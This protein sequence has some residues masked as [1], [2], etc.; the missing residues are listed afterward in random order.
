MTDNLASPPADPYALYSHWQVAAR[1]AKLLEPQAAALATI[2]AD[3]A[4]AVRMVLLKGQ[5]HVG[6]DFCTNFESRKAQELAADAR[7][8]LVVWWDRVHRQV[9]VEG[10]VQRLSDDE[11]DRY[12]RRRPR[13]SQVSAWASPQSRAIES[14]DALVSKVQEIGARFKGEDVPRPPFWGCYR[15]F[16]ERI[17]FWQGRENRLHDRVVYVAAG[18]DGWRIERLAP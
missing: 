6:F 9:R 13:A 1:E 8:A 15:L 11:S 7:A 10:L 3:G 17:E 16:P 4:P 12:H 2:G 14:R 5:A 18:A